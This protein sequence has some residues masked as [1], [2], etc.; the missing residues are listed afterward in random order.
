MT[1]QKN[2]PAT[3]SM[4]S[5]SK[6]LKNQSDKQIVRQRTAFNKLRATGLS[7]PKLAAM[8]PDQLATEY[9]RILILQG[10]EASA[11]DSGRIASARALA[12]T[13]AI[14][15]EQTSKG[16]EATEVELHPTDSMSAYDAF[17]WHLENK[18][19]NDEEYK[20]YLHEQSKNKPGT[21]RGGLRGFLI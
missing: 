6:F 19:K 17:F 1:E 11:R 7:W 4:I 3:G 9:K 14:Y 5:F 18:H 16:L 2:T 12:K 20:K 8:N 13:I 15:I 21:R 10:R